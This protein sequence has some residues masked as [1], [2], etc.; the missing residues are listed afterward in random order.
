LHEGQAHRR[1][2]FTRSGD[3]V[4]ETLGLAP[5]TVKDRQKLHEALGLSAEAREAFADGRL[6]ESK[7]IVLLPVLRM[8]PA[9]VVM[10]Q[11]LLVA[12]GLSV[13]CLRCAVREYVGAG[14]QEGSGSAEM[15]PEEES[16]EGRQIG[17]RGPVPVGRMFDEA[18][19][20]AR[21]ML[22][23]RAPRYRCVEALLAETS[24]RCQRMEP[25][26]VERIEAH[27]AERF[28]AHAE[29]VI[30]RSSGGAARR[31]TE[32]NPE[33]EEAVRAVVLRRQLEA[34]RESSHGSG[35]S[36]AKQETAPGSAAAHRG[37]NPLAIQGARKLVEQIEED[38]AEIEGLMAEEEAPPSAG[39]D[40]PPEGSSEARSGTARPVSAGRGNGPSE[41]YPDA[42]PGTVSL[43]GRPWR[44]AACRVSD[45]QRAAVRISRRCARPHPGRDLRRDRSRDRLRAARCAASH[46]PRR[47]CSASCATA[48]DG[49]LGT[50]WTDF[51]QNY[52]RMSD[53]AAR[54]LVAEGRLFASE[55]D[56]RGA[57]GRGEVSLGAAFLLKR[58]GGSG[59]VRG[60]R[61]RAAGLTH[62][63]LAREV[64]LL[65]WGRQVGAR[66]ALRGEA[67]EMEEELMRLLGRW[68]WTRQRV[69]SVL[70]AIGLS[71]AAVG[72]PGEDPGAMSRLERMIDLLIL[73]IWD[74]PP[75][76]EEEP[77][78]ERRMSVHAGAMMEV[79]F[80]APESVAK[81]WR[82]AVGRIRERSG[83]GSPP[84]VAVSMLVAEALHE[85]EREDPKRKPREAKILVRD[86]YRCMV[87]ICSGMG[88]LEV[89]HMVYLSAGGSEEE[90]NKV[91]LCHGHHRMVHEGIVRSGSARRS[92]TWG[93][94]ATDGPPDAPQ[95][96][97]SWRS[98]T[99]VASAAR[100]ERIDYGYPASPARRYHCRFRAEAYSSLRRM[101]EKG[102]PCGH[103][104]IIGL[105]GCTQAAAT[106]RERTW[107]SAEDP[108][109]CLPRHWRR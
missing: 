95:G 30:S 109:S 38:L 29:A 85:W 89:H 81:D 13:R 32:G 91:T 77:E 88:Q 103:A 90:W 12:G 74:D 106:R 25:H 15:D 14:E 58:A 100:A 49:I 78:G 42:Q 76:P 86:D 94:G 59:S 34:N 92:L 105:L 51:A 6:S 20:T 22:G 37:V 8:R 45:A 104:L 31:Q 23:S 65:E 2:G 63:Q 70:E 64:R 5:S 98:F 46:L 52:L 47:S 97:E 53:R 21:K 1:L 61:E 87:P 62:Q 41:G 7:A 55:V 82:D 73:T 84:W 3:F 57:Y 102:R 71:R 67:G 44:R 80:W 54:S 69:G 33:I 18:I 68:G 83:V 72:D 9:G 107:N 43:V 99:T 96:T 36:E 39:G 75:K 11:W 108:H 50:D 27:C 4:R 35:G 48:R 79:R 16:E 60:M 26:L 56:L 24:S 28:G 93:S 66:L 40:G 101:P 17:F 10:E 19:G